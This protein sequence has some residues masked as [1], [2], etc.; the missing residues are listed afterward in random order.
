MRDCNACIDRT[1]CCR[2][3]FVKDDGGNI[4]ENI[5]FSNIDILEQD[6]D[7]SN[8]QGC[9]AISASDNNL[10]RNITYENIRIEDI[11]EGQLFNF[12]VYFNEKYKKQVISL[13]KSKLI[14]PYYISII[15]LFLKILYHKFNII[16]FN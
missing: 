11:Q 6:E 8:Y 12:R 15:L 5:T 14:I 9:L 7:D 16:P 2:Q 13:H 1:E 4:I 10:V 3:N